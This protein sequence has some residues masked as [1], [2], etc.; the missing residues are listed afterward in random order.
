MSV[1]CTAYIIKMAATALVLSYL[2]FTGIGRVYLGAHSYNQVIFG[3]TLG[4]LLAY[5]LH[6][7]LKPWFYE[8]PVT[9]FT[10][11]GEVGHQKYEVTARHYILAL[12]VWLVAPACM[13]LAIFTSRL[14][15][16]EKWMQQTT[17]VNKMETEGCREL[18]VSVEYL[19]H[20]H[21][22]H[23]SVIAF[24]CGSIIGQL[25][26]WQFF[27]NKLK[28]SQWTWHETGF[29]LTIIRILLTFV[30]ISCFF[31]APTILSITDIDGGQ[32]DVGFAFK[33]LV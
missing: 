18:M 17:W 7:E 15:D 11:S 21:F 10:S 28:T 26:E 29:V 30:F 14:D 27:S 24:S 3:A 31:L 33:Y 6:Y 20:R 19:N 23:S 2:M 25:A 12:T 8:L 13:A 22:L 32:S 16:D 5:V 4:L 9:L 1:F